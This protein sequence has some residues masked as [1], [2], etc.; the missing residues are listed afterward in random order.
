MS[1]KVCFWRWL[2]RSRR[3]KVAAANKPCVI[4]LNDLFGV[5]C[6]RNNIPP[7]T[8]ARGLTIKQF[9]HEIDNSENAFVIVGM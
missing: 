3:V 2:G 9:V 6:E 1:R 5:G 8:A 4:Y 7:N